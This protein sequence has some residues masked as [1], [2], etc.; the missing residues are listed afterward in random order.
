MLPLAAHGVEVA[1][2]ADLMR[3]NWHMRISM[4]TCVYIVLARRG[5]RLTCLEVHGSCKSGKQGPLEAASACVGSPLQ[6]LPE[7]DS[8]TRR[9]SFYDGLKLGSN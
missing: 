6:R 7:H 3:M 5:P 4:G 9:A 2:E 8:K 1:V